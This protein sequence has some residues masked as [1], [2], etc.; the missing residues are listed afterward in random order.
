MS[1][2]GYALDYAKEIA[3]DE[4]L[5]AHLTSDAVVHAARTLIPQAQLDRPNWD[6]SSIF[7]FGLITYKAEGL[8][9]R[10]AIFGLSR[11]DMRAFVDA[12]DDRATS[13]VWDVVG[14]PVPG[15]Y[16]RGRKIA[17]RFDNFD[18]YTEPRRVKALKHAR[19][20]LARHKRNRAKWGG[21]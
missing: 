17:A 12:Y 14:D 21:K 6:L 9:D 3:A 18:L 2:W 4:A 11:E 13:E 20:A 10:A 19:T 7:V 15:D 16:A 1:G 5:I 8:L